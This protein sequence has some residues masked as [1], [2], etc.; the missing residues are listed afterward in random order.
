MTIAKV[1]FPMTSVSV[2]D[3]TVHPMGGFGD[4]SLEI[5][6]SGQR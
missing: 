5:H 2:T 6:E 3:N 1:R 4:R